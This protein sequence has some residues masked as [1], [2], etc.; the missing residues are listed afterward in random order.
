MANKIAE[1]DVKISA[2][3]ISEVLKQVINFT[4]LDPDEE[5]VKEARK[6]VNRKVSASK[7]VRTKKTDV[8]EKI[9]IEPT[10]PVAPPVQAVETTTVTGSP[11]G[12]GV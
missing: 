5:K 4:Y 3:E 6:L 1:K 12:T 2:E 10:A 8:V 11:Q 7:R 9:E